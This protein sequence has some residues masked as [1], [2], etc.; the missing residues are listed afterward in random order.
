MDG[1]NAGTIIFD[2]LRDGSPHDL[3]L[4]EMGGPEMY[5]NHG[6][7]KT[8]E[9]MDRD[10]RVLR[11]WP[12]T[13]RCGYWG[14]SPVKQARMRYEQ[15]KFRNQTD[16]CS[17]EEFMSNPRIRLIGGE[18]DPNRRLLLFDELIEEGCTIR[19]CGMDFLSMGYPMESISANSA[20]M[21]YPLSNW[22]KP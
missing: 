3:V 17:L 2:F 22:M 21:V 6:W 20:A 10:M 1:Y 12:L 11:F 18:P 5:Y 15:A 7:C 8:L 19:S 4:I 16:G 14:E 13:K 9:R